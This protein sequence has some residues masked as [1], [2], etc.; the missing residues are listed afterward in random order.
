MSSIHSPSQ[1]LS[2][3][4]L[5]EVMKTISNP[6]VENLVFEFYDVL[7]FLIIA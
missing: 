7:K 5:V 2:H 3:S 6:E 1:S 4:V